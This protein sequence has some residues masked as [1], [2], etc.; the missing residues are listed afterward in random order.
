MSQYHLTEDFLDANILFWPPTLLIDGCPKGT[1][2]STAYE[3]PSEL[4]LCVLEPSALG[5][6]DT[7]GPT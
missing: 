3:N 2:T 6:S 4:V 5:V 7:T 1:L